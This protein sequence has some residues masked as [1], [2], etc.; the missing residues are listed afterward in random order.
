MNAE[1][2]TSLLKRKNFII[3]Y[4]ILHSLSAC[5]K[6]QTIYPKADALSHID[7]TALIKKFDKYFYYAD[8]TNQLSYIDSAASVF[9]N[10]DIAIGYPRLVGYMYNVA[11][12]SQQGHLYHNDSSK[13]IT[14]LLEQFKQL[15]IEADN[16]SLKTWALYFE[17]RFFN[18][19]KQNEI[20]LPKFLTTYQS[21][22]AQKDI[23]GISVV[24]KRIGL[25]YL[26]DYKDYNKAKYFLTSALLLAKDSSEV[27]IISSNLTKVY[28][29][30]NN[31]DSA[32]LHLKNVNQQNHFLETQPL[33]QV[34]LYQN[35]SFGNADSVDAAINNLLYFLNG[36]M[37]DYTKAILISVYAKFCFALLKN[38]QLDLAL[39][40]IKKGL[41][42]N[43]TCNTCLT[44]QIEIYHAR[45]FYHQYIKDFTNAFSYLQ[46]YNRSVDLLNFERTKA[47]VEEAR[48][49]YEFERQ[50]NELAL[51][52][53]KERLAI[54]QNLQKQKI[55][56]NSF[57]A[58][59]I[60]LMLLIIV[61]INRNKLKRTIEMEKMRS[62]LSRD[63]HD[64]IGSSLSSI[65][66]LSRTAQTNL[67][68]SGDEKTKASL[69]KINERSQRLLDNMSDI[70]WN[71]NPG[72]DTIEEVMSRMR[73]YATTMLEAKNIDYDFNFPK[74]K[75]D[76]RLSMEVK[77]NIYLI[78]KE[79]VNNLCKYSGCT[80]ASLSLTFNEKHIHLK[81]GDN[82]KG[83][84]ED[85]LKHRGG[86]RNMQHR[87]EEIKGLL[88]LKSI[89]GKGTEVELI[90]PRYC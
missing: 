84:I 55:I 56:R 33:Y 66:I 32:T 11:L 16:E 43:A 44:E 57:I 69:E 3:G 30:L 70:I 13:I 36:K 8:S 41:Q 51:K 18:N 39:K 4:I 76:C 74:E 46:E 60:L 1:R 89:I 52:Q 72:N 47:S 26:N 61:L 19:C 68:N 14:R 5:T 79:A 49:K 24:T 31:L 50:Q 7:T 78:F 17:A 12:Q 88:K 25:V 71:I 37:T 82:G 65:N 90:M 35:T 59:S 63:L 86:L 27:S 28:L 22:K 75:I 21:F 9:N 62:R 45:Y 6:N 38:N 73:E 2:F 20:A 48:I 42:L 40:C 29:Q 34:Y 15:A 53:E 85:E 54:Q 64:D 77:N 23:D 67:L 83:F 80:H 87:A 10:V 58:G 81:I